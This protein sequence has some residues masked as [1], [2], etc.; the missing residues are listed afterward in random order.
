MRFKLLFQSYK[1]QPIDLQCKPN[2]TT[3]FSMSG[4]SN[5]KRFKICRNKY[6]G[7]RH[8]AEINALEHAIKP[9]RFH[10]LLLTMNIYFPTGLAISNIRS[11]KNT[12]IAM[13]L[14]KVNSKDIRTTFQDVNL[15][16]LLLTLRGICP[17]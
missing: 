2:Q 15:L 9:F 16:G 3:G 7:T 5:K 13:D 10:F 6:T 1:N 4:V 8:Q 11:F 14:F 17:A 12:Q